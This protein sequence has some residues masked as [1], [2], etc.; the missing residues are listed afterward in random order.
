MKSIKSRQRGI[1]LMES[2]IALVVLALGIMGLAGVQTRILAESRTS[3][4]RAVAIG[5]IDDLNN[6]M[7]LN[8]NAALY[9]PIPPYNLDWADAATAVQ[10][11]KTNPCSGAQLAQS[12]LNEW[13]ASVAAAL[14]GGKTSVFLSPTDSRQVGIAIGWNANEG[15]AADTDTDK[16]KSPFAVTADLHGVECP[17]NSICHFAY[18]QP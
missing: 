18:V 3:N 1:S 7:L 11:C 2:L 14:P 9:S 10:D 13:R 17:A 6:R 12:D 8:R 15:K 5:L 4:H 16:Y